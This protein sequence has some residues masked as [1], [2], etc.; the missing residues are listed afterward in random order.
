MIS[1]IALDTAEL[2]DGG[3]TLRLVQ[4]RGSYTIMPGANGLMSSRMS[5]SEEELARIGW[6]RMAGRPARRVPI[7]GLGMGFA[8]RAAVAV[9]PAVPAV[10]VAELIPEV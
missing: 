10:D 4:H 2:P 7:G 9:L 1:R 6:G 3:G 5:G 8:M